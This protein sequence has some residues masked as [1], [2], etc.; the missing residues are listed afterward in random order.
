MDIP[1]FE[2][3]GV[4]RPTCCISCNRLLSLDPEDPYFNP[5]GFQLCR[6]CRILRDLRQALSQLSRSNLQRHLFDWLEQASIWIL[7]INLYVLDVVEEVF[8][9]PEFEDYL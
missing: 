8:D 9:D 2:T 4:F 7:E 3:V 5:R 6:L 1:Y